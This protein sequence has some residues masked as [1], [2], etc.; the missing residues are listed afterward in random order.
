MTLLLLLF[1]CEIP[2]LDSA[3]SAAPGDSAAPEDSG[4]DGPV[5]PDAP[6]TVYATRHCEK[7]TEGDDP[8]L[9]EE[10]HARAEALA[11]RMREVPLSAVYATEY[12]RTQ[13]TVQ[14]TADEH[15]L[16]VQ[17]DLDPEEALAE[18][19]LATHGGE[20]VLHAGHSYTLLDFM[21]ALGVAE[22]P[23]DTEYGD[24]WTIV[25]DVDGTATI[26][27]ERYGD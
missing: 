10:G 27:A 14:P 1:A 7:E 20:E 19:L 22:L 21:D 26:A 6:L 4:E 17:I 9:T 25:V 24:L 23:E 18:H 8:G 16:E 13:E 15:G 11:V 3:D 12:R 5:L 2:P